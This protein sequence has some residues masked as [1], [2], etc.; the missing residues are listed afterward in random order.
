MKPGFV[1]IGSMAVILLGSLSA[2][3]AAQQVYR[4]ELSDGSITFS[5]LPCRSDIGR[6]DMVDA[7]PHQGHRPAATTRPEPARR[8]DP[9]TADRDR[10]GTVGSS[11]GR[12]G[13]ERTLSRNERL[14]LEHSRKRLLSGL[15]RR[16]VDAGDRRELIRELRLVDEKLGIGPADVLDMPFHDREVYEE[17]PVYPGIRRSGPGG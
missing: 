12:A 5:D 10:G 9:G 8:T 4:C 14:S 16:H 3:S 11:A 1:M 13:R 6:H 7:T 2:E 15:K 17:N